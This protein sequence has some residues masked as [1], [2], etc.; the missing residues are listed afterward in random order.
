M[1]KFEI[2]SFSVPFIRVAIVDDHKVVADGFERIVNESEQARVIGKAYSAAG[3][4]ELIDATTPDVLLLDI[5]LTDGNGIDLCAKIKEKY[6]QVKV[7]M[8]SGYGELFTINRALKAGADG[9]MLKSSMSEEVIDGICTVVSGER[10]FPYDIQF[11]Q[12]GQ[13]NIPQTVI[14]KRMLPYPV[15]IA[16]EY[17]ADNIALPAGIPEIES[18]KRR[19]GNFNYLAACIRLALPCNL[20]QIQLHKLALQRDI[21]RA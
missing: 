18:I 19:R 20:R 2:T 9:Y 10:G 8:L 21:E 4:L 11:A 1:K 17:Q 13:V 14:S 3:C 7:L 12:P 5:G 15:N 6:P 16:G